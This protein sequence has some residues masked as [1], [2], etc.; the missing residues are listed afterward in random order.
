MIPAEIPDPA[1]LKVNISIRRDLWRRLKIRKMDRGLRDL[2]AVIRELE[3]LAE[4][5]EAA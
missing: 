1:Y 4:K 2:D 3:A 5:Q